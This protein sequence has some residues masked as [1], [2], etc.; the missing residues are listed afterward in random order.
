MFKESYEISL[1]NRNKR[2]ERE[3]EKG[4]VR[5]VMIYKICDK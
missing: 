2:R 4:K 1:N 3:R 5:E